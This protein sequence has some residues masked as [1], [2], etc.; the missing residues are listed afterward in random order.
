[1]K[2]DNCQFLLDSSLDCIDTILV[3]KM[4]LADIEENTEEYIVLENRQIPKSL[5]S[6]TSIIFS[7]NYM[8]KLLVDKQHWENIDSYC[9]KRDSTGHLN[10]HNPRRF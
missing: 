3:D 10:K 8:Y 7:P 1:M 6:S 9:Y 2:A 5:Y 4:N